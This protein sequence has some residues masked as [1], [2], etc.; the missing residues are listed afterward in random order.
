MNDSVSGREAQAGL[1]RPLDHAAEGEP[2]VITRDGAPVAAIVPVEEGNAREERG[3]RRAAGGHVTWADAS[4]H[5]APRALASAM[6]TRAGL[7]GAYG[8]VSGNS[9]RHQWCSS[10]F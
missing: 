1:A 2:T 4:P 7:A 8:S 6:T 9:T 3:R 10:S 5:V